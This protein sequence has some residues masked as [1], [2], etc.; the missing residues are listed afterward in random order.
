MTERQAKDL[1]QPVLRDLCVELLKP[2]L[3]S[4]NS[5][6]IDGTLGLGGHTEAVLESIPLVTVVGIDRDPQAL[7]LASRRLESFGPRFIP[8]L[9]TYDQVGE[10]ARQ[11]GNRGRADAIL[12]DLGV[13]SLQLDESSRGFAYSQDGPLDMRMNQSQGISAAEL[14]ATA[15]VSELTRIIRTYGEE[16]FAS[17]IAHS[18]IK[19]RD[20]EP[21]KTTGELADL[22]KE[23]IPAAARR[24]GGNPAK[25]TFQ[26]L[27]IAVNDELAILERTIPASLSS[28][29][30]GGRL[31]V[32]AY[33]SLEDRIVK[34]VFNRGLKDQAP[35]GLPVVPE[36][37]LPRLK[38]LISGAY[39]AD[40]EEIAINP[41]AKSVRLRAVELIAPWSKNEP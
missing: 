14:L 4:P 25:R 34:N 29:R 7:K 32:E 13:S 18:I 30:V 39:Q 8:F 5:L 11:Y 36:Q 31:V 27:R 19:R 15:S 40:E 37:D 33:Q 22:V 9:G 3:T 20:Q 17:K 1:H 16:R 26:A 12:L 6:L 21:I 10:V 23:S 28:L 35:V 41:R 38:A 2:A 24:K